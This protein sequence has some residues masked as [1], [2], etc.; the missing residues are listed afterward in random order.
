MGKLIKK[1]MFDA[2]IKPIRASLVGSEKTLNF[3][4]NHH[5]KG[6]NGMKAQLAAF[7]WLNHCGAKS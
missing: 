4:K 7:F 3:E 5:K 6:C 2:M 1:A